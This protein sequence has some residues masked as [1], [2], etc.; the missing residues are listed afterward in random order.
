MATLLDMTN[1]L[2]ALLREEPVTLISATD[3]LTQTL[4][5][6][7]NK[8]ARKV[9]AGGEWPAFEVRDNGTITYAAPIESTESIL[10]NGDTAIGFP[11]TAD[12]HSTITGQPTR[13]L[14]TNASGVVNT[15]YRITSASNAGGTELATINP[16]FLGSSMVLASLKLFANE[17][18]LPS[19]V[20]QVLSV[21]YEERPLDLVFVER[22]IHLDSI[23]P[24]D[25][26]SFQDP[27]TVYV[28]GIVTDT[29]DSDVATSGTAGMGMTI[30]PPPD[31]AKE[32]KYSYVYT[33]PAM[34]DA[35]DTLE[36]VPETV[37]DLVVDNALEMCFLSNIENDPD[38]AILAR[39]FNEIDA[40][41]AQ[42]AMRADPNRRRIPRP[43]SS[44]FSDVPRRRWNTQEV[45]TP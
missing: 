43:K 20:R 16:G 32:L 45:P 30:W 9:L 18:R 34:A 14:V 27:T 1:D 36:G 6:V 31:A 40:K 23:V 13:M 4:V 29:Y 10:G 3:V 37:T 24:R 22:H 35:T 28:G 11:A 33:P 8:A 12:E 5:R 19:T 21:R 42:R 2:R 7:L 41:K 44:G 38:R 25:F 17:R 26:D 15:S 39:R